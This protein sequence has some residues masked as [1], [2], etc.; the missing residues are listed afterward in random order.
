[1]SETE[2]QSYEEKPNSAELL[3]DK[4]IEDGTKAAKD[5]FL[6]ISDMLDTPA[7]R[8][9]ADN[10]SQGN[11]FEKIKFGDEKEMSPYDLVAEDVKEYMSL[12]D[13]FLG[14]GKN[15]EAEQYR[16]ERT[17]AEKISD[18]LFKLGV[19]TIG[20]DFEKSVLD[21]GKETDS[22]KKTEI[23]SPTS[24]GKRW[25]LNMG[26]KK[27]WQE[28]PQENQ[29]EEPESIVKK[30]E[31]GQVKEKPET[32][33][34]ISKSIGEKLSEENINADVEFLSDPNFE[35]DIKRTVE[36]F[37]NITTNEKGE[38]RHLAKERNEMV[39]LNIEA[40]GGRIIR[41]KDAIEKVRQ[42]I[43]E[44]EALK[45][46][47]ELHEKAMETLIARLPEKYKSD[48]NALTIYIE[49][50]KDKLEL[51]GPNRDLAFDKLVNDGYL[52]EH[53]KKRW[54]SY[55]FKI[56]KTGEKER[57]LYNPTLHFETLIKNA[58]LGVASTAQ[59]RASLKI[60]QGREKMK[61]E[62]KKSMKEI[63][64]GAILDYKTKQSEKAK[65]TK[66]SKQKNTPAENWSKKYREE[67]LREIQE[68]QSR[69]EKISGAD[70]V[71]LSKLGI[72]TNPGASLEGENILEYLQKNITTKNKTD[73]KYE[74]K[75]PKKSLKEE[76]DPAK[77]GGRT[78]Q[79]RRKEGIGLNP[80]RKRIIKKSKR[81]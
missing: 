54:F 12:E 75:K 27:N 48:K 25:K 73:T 23:S 10:V 58:N 31:E 17:K 4:E 69:G 50:I 71:V 24:K 26:D 37:R 65:T 32:K 76:F 63:V 77:N 7:L 3:T 38:H 16:K 55:E 14:Q 80:L 47:N 42:E 6:E 39:A 35:K 62:R 15:V 81:P 49:N 64:A 51:V 29:A 67:R 36:A 70:K 66:T 18:F 74:R 57:A 28:V 79:K 22:Q 56:P 21:L 60:E 33:K 59:E 19:K 40:R 8:E 11:F 44:K 43:T 13:R 34:Q 9:I 20:E 46:K 2:K 45:I 41:G 30:E 72:K 68:K 52:V 53:A 1:M 5:Y 78:F 61:Q